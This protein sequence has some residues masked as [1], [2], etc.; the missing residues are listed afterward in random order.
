MIWIEVRSQKCSQDKAYKNLKIKGMFKDLA[1][2]DRD[3]FLDLRVQQEYIIK[4]KL[5]AILSLVLSISL[6]GVNGI[7]SNQEFD[8]TQTENK[9]VCAIDNSQCLNS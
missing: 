6:I 3:Y 1:Y 4:E 5:L 2:L 9:K 8:R 7:V